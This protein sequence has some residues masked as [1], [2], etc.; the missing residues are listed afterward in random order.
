M[1]DVILVSGLV[2]LAHAFMAL[3]LVWGSLR[4]F[5]SL[6]G[7]QF[8]EMMGSMKNDANSMAVYFGLRFIGACLLF[9]FVIS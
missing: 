2:T 9:G 3:M 6:G 4:L 7:I 8:K 1:T 5:D